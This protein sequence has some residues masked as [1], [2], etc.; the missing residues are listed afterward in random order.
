MK[1]GIYSVFDEKAM[2]FGMPML[3][4]REEEAIRSFTSIVNNGESMLSAYPNDYKLY[5]LGTMCD[6]SGKID[7]V[8]QPTFVR[9]ALDVLVKKE[10]AV[11]E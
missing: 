3:F 8:P 10:E 11:K 6:T 5:F 9:H 7:C 1:K 4:I 2:T